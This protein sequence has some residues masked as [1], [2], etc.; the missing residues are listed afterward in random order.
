MI[1]RIQ[2]VYLI[3]I[4]FINI[5]YIVSIN[6]FQNINFPK[7]SIEFKQIFSFCI[8]IV[9]SILLPLTSLFLYKYRNRQLVINKINILIQLIFLLIVLYN[10]FKNTTIISFDFFYF[11][12]S[13]NIIFMILA[14]Y[15]I[16]KDE[17]FSSFRI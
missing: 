15:G 7:I 13:F 5:I 4:V 10:T 8:Y 16:N 1:Q 12:V 6:N 11:V 2:S 14:N 17:N 3:L 9:I